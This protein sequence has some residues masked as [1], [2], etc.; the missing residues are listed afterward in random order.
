MS[1]SSAVLAAEP[2]ASVASFRISSIWSIIGISDG[3]AMKRVAARLHLRGTLAYPLQ[4]DRSRR[5]HVE[6]FC[7]LAERN[8][9]LNP[10][11]IQHLGGQ[12]RPLGAQADRLG[13]CECL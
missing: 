12:P 7:A 5:R 4:R 9:D 11:A 13:A 2:I 10:A 6:R 3:F 8:R 1:S